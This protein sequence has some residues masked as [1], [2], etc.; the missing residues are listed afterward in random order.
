[1]VYEIL[2]DYDSYFEWLPAVTHSR[3]LAREGDLAV[4]ELEMA[5]R[6]SRLAFE[7]IQTRN[8]RVMTRKI[9][10]DAP[11]REVVW[12]LAPAADGGT[13]VSV[14]I[15]F[16]NHPASLFSPVRRHANASRYLEALQSRVTMFSVRVLFDEEAGRKVLEVLETNEGLDLWILGKRYTLKPACEETHD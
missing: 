15:R 5:G 13:Q 4:A 3:L 14:G 11:L 2:T 9:S 8:K 7:C 16:E 6:D 10:G 12:S 1:M